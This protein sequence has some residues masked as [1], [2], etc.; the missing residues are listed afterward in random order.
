MK[1]PQNGPKV[2]KLHFLLNKGHFN[3]ACNISVVKGS[4]K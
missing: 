1:G 3:F 4:I 2:L